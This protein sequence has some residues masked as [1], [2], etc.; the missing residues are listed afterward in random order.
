[1]KRIRSIQFKVFICL[2]ISF[3]VVFGYIVKTKYDQSFNELLYYSQSSTSDDYINY[4]TAISNKNGEYREFDLDKIKQGLSE[5]PKDDSTKI[6]LLDTYGNPIEQYGY[7]KD[8]HLLI[9]HDPFVE[10]NESDV[11]TD[12][13]DDFYDARYYIDLSSLSSEQYQLLIETIKD[14]EKKEYDDI[15]LYF[16]GKIEELK[17]F[18]DTSQSTYNAKNR[19][20]KVKPTFI[21]YNTDIFG[22]KKGNTVEAFYEAYVE[23]GEV[24]LKKNEEEAY[25]DTRVS[26]SKINELSKKAVNEHFSNVY[27]GLATFLDDVSIDSNSQTAIKKTNEIATSLKKGTL[28]YASFTKILDNYSYSVLLLP[29]DEHHGY[30][31][32]QEPA[33]NALIAVFYDFQ[34]GGRNQLKNDLFKDNFPLLLGGFLFIV[35]FSYL[36]SYMTTRRI[37]EIDRVAMEITNNN[38]EGV[39]DTKGHDELSSLSSHINTMSS[40]LKRNIDALN[41]E[42]DQVKKMEQLRKEFIAQF[43]HEIKTPL[44]IINGNIDLLENVDDEDKKA[45]YIEVINKEIAVIND[46]VLQMLDLSKLEAKAITLDKKE[47]DLRELSEDIIDDYEQLL[48]DKKLKIEI[49]GED[50][51]IVGDRKRIEM[52]IQNYLSNA[53]KHA[54]IN[55]TIK[56]KIKENEFSIE[57]KGKQIDENRMDSIW[58]SFV[59][60]D[61]KGT[62]LGLAIVRNILEL[63]E[64]SY[65][66][67]N[68]QGGVEFYFRWKK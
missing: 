41:L 67:Y 17:N 21:H 18:K 30:V 38:F 53:I 48:M 58:E 56:I 45:K 11:D 14:V 39:L 34:S 55:S 20:Y 47:I 49:Q 1:M 26:T 15:H 5:L 7:E 44:A 22:Q 24:H 35:L 29:L 3:M 23:N 40:N 19:Y 13:S 62:G 2:F 65:G 36:I 59:S 54:F 12:Y 32:G 33:P 61:Q 66:V 10:I 64:M 9:V 46:L 50:V 8:D 25:G 60:D 31:E 6:Y 68:L 57:N 16:E 52:V 42:I 4:C 37:K 63:H 43:T 28:T 51:L 27:A